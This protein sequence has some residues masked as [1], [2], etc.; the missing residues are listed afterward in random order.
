MCA[1]SGVRALLSPES[2]RNNHK[3]KQL[4]SPHPRPHSPDNRYIQV[5]CVSRPRAGG[6]RQTGSV[7]SDRSQ[8]ISDSKRQGQTGIPIQHGKT[9]FDNMKGLAE[10]VGAATIT[11][12]GLFPGAS[13]H[14]LQQRMV[15][16]GLAGGAAAL[17]SPETMTQVGDRPEQSPTAITGG[18]G[19][20][21]EHRTLFSSDS[22]DVVS[23]DDALDAN[24]SVS[25][26]NVG[27]N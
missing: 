18:G 6:R 27:M 20:R 11:T 13:G 10:W 7:N 9:G 5:Y 14:A 21:P 24:G 23:S 19:G 4:P 15:G 12:L 8:H 22:N 1:W 16:N 25:P 26:N 3:Y 2:Y 17:G